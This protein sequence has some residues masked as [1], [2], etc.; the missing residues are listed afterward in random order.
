M[1]Y[2]KLARVSEIKVRVAFFTGVPGVVQGI[3]TIVV[4][5]NA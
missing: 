3:W 2:C 5:Q 1:V 4:Q